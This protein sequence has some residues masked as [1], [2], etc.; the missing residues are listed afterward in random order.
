MSQEFYWKQKLAVQNETTCCKT[1][2]TDPYEEVFFFLLHTHQILHI[3]HWLSPL[4][5]IINV[6]CICSFVRNIWCLLLK[7]LPSVPCFCITIR[8][9][10]TFNFDAVAFVL[11]M[12]VHILALHKDKCP[13]WS[14]VYSTFQAQS[15]CCSQT[16]IIQ[17]VLFI[18]RPRAA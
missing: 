17:C 12:Q 1:R 18:S 14:K 2:N 9:S 8:N 5:V 7:Q 6:Y 10:L 11:R 3:K 15:N 16:V 13:P 4:T